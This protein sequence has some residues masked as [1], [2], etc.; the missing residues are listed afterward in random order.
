ME[1]TDTLAAADGAG[2]AARHRRR[3]LAALAGLGV[4]GIVLAA[5]A[6]TQPAETWTRAREMAEAAVG[7]VRGL[8][9][10][11]FFL[12]FAVL[13]AIGFPVSVFALAAGPLFG[14]VLGL[15]AV[16]AL[17]LGCMAVSMTLSYVLARHVVRPWV[18]RLLGFLGYTIPVV[19]SEKRRM[20]VFLVRVTPGPPYV[21][22]NFLLGLAGVPFR[23]YFWI[24]W[25][26][27]SASVSLFVVFGDAVMKGRGKVA[28]LALAGVV[29]VVAV[30]KFARGRVA[31]AGAD[32]EA[33]K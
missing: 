26:I 14:P 9:A 17:T 4:A 31:R 11:W 25:V 27:S 5:W 2:A 28:L 22:Q 8:G 19:P 24:S 32:V 7:A 33:G 12:A 16:L 23:V 30:L 20:F 13:P 10:H 15:P 6:A 29:G 21:F 1:S 3:R 18:T